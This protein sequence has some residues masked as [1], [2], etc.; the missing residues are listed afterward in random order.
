MLFLGLCK[1]RFRNQGNVWRF[2][3]Y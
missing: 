2:M 3:S 1:N